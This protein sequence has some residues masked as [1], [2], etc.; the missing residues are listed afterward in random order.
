MS[1]MAEDPQLEVQSNIYVEDCSSL[2]RMVQFFKAEYK[3]KT[4][5]SVAK[6]VAEQLR[7]K[8]AN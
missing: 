7:R 4:K 8:L 1:N 5:L 2:E 3:G 6:R